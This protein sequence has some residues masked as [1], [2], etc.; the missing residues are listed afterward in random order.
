MLRSCSTLG[1]ASH[2]G[3]P[4]APHCRWHPASHL[5]SHLSGTQLHSPSNTQLHTCTSLFAHLHF[6]AWTTALHHP[7]S[8]TPLSRWQSPFVPRYSWQKN[9]HKF[10]IYNIDF[11]FHKC[12][13]K[14]RSFDVTHRMHLY[15]SITM[16]LP[17][18]T[19][20]IWIYLHKLSHM[21]NISHSHLVKK[22]LVSDI[23]IYDYYYSYYCLLFD[24]C[25]EG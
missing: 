19:T 5:R 25:I 18:V 4:L 6:T 3:S 1:W 21:I 23:D 2:S 12:F 13:H 16:N 20:I 8:C 7:N 9:N 24:V 17:L 22:F 10:H 15:V 11:V 14:L